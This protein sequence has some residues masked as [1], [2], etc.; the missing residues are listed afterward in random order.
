MYVH[1]G[2]NEALLFW[3]IS[4]VYISKGGMSRVIKSIQDYYG[5]ERERERA[6]YVLVYVHS[7]IINIIIDYDTIWGQE[8]RFSRE[9]IYYEGK[10]EQNVR[11]E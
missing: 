4:F 10:E 8:M 2:I 1:L 6:I 7:R 11:S 5:E 9:I 3:I